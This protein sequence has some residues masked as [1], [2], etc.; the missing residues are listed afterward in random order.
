MSWLRIRE[1][2]RNGEERKRGALVYLALMVTL[3]WLLSNS[4]ALDFLKL[5]HHKPSCQGWILIG[6][7]ELPCLYKQHSSASLA[8]C[9]Q[10]AGV[11]YWL[12]NKCSLYIHRFFYDRKLLCGY[13]KCK[14]QCGLECWKVYIGLESFF[15]LRVSVCVCLHM[16]T[17]YSHRWDFYLSL[18]LLMHTTTSPP[19]HSRARIS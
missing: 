19:V 15:V 17:L 4:H 3:L 9:K 16:W 10:T 8:K 18:R 14:Y 1:A 5:P 2:K 12:V 11:Q 7:E 6:W 13:V